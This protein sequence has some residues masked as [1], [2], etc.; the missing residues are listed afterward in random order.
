MPT[1][2][3]VSRAAPAPAAATVSQQGAKSA[4]P[5]STVFTQGGSRLANRDF[6]ENFVKSSYSLDVWHGCLQSLR[7]YLRGWSLKIAREN[8]EIKK[9]ISNRIEEIDIT[10][11]SDF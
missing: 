2:L 6:K 4:P 8:K 1:V 11:E 9:N 5:S 10:A 7:K 3:Q